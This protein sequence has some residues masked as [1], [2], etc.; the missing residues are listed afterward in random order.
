M[1]LEQYDRQSELR[2]HCLKIIEQMNAIKKTQQSVS[3]LIETMN[4]W[5][6]TTHSKTV[7]TR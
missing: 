3:E 2:Y 4:R 1:N 6:V 5:P 7:T